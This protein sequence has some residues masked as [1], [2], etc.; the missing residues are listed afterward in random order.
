VWVPAH[1]HTYMALGVVFFLIG[2][3]YHVLPEV[4]GRALSDRL[5]MRAAPLVILGGWGLVSMWYLAGVL[6]QPRRY[7]STLPGLEGTA[8]AGAGF[9]ALAALGVLLLFGDFVRA[10]TGRRPVGPAS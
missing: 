3:V 10:V 9:A 8:A 6:G 7:P 1:F 2:A 4:T 5:G